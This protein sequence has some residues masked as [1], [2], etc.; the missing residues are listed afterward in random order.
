MHSS[1]NRISSSKMLHC[2]VLVSHRKRYY[3]KMNWATTEIHKLA[4]E[5][6]KLTK[7]NTMLKLTVLH[8]SSY[9]DMVLKQLQREL[10]LL[11]RLN[12]LI[13]L[14]AQVTPPGCC[15]WSNKRMCAGG[16]Y[17]IWYFTTHSIRWAIIITMTRLVKSCVIQKIIDSINQTTKTPVLI[18]LN[19]CWLLVL[20]NCCPKANN[21]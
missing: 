2:T 18:S 17:Y 13:Q 11:Y 4:Q 6:R 9:A 10:L 5:H 12:F 16:N 14:H 19:R 21:M 1:Y 7:Q 15:P 8:W 20:A 3:K